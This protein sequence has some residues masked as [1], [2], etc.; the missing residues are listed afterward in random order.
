MML[1]LSES[2]TWSAEVGRDGIRLRVRSGEV[3]VT[4]QRDELDHVVHAHETFDSNWKGRLVVLA[5]TP[6]RVEVTSL[7]SPARSAGRIAHAAA[8]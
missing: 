2:Q 6:A 8:R 4:R 7:A 1:E 3:W 5:L